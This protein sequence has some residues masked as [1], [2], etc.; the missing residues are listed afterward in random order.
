MF[1]GHR[2]E[3]V[4]WCRTASGNT[5]G[6][7]LVGTS[8]GLIMECCIEAGEETKFFGGSVDQYFK[9]VFTFGKGDGKS[10]FLPLCCL[11]AL[12]TSFQNV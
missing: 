9:Q 10:K 6:P 7:V 12:E 1:L 8:R 5:T 2:I 11:S 4:A 3:S